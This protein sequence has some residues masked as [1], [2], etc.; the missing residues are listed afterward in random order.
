MPE[1]IVFLPDMLCDARLFGPQLAALSGRR[2][3]MAA[4]ITGGERIEEIASNLLDQLPKRSAIV[5]CGMGGAVALE[6]VRRAPDRLTRLCLMDSS[7]LQDTPQQAAAR[8]PLLIRAR[9]GKFESVI[10]EAL[11]LGDLVASPWR[12][13]VAALIRDMALGL[14]PEVLVRQTRAWQRRKDQ[15][16]TLRRINMP[17]LV[18][19]GAEN[20]QL[21]VKRHEFMAELIPGAHLRVIEDAAHFSMLEQPDAVADALSDWLAMPLVLR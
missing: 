1:P 17:T 15:Q 12:G 2:A 7:P 3:V 10:D 6:I 13:E 8:D 14:G 11:H 9:A 19:C 20:R 18:V 21:P 16:G 5:G 4:P